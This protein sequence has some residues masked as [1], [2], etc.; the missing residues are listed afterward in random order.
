MPKLDK[1]KKGKKYGMRYA[2]MWL[3][4]IYLY[5]QKKKIHIYSTNQKNI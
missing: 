2:I 4:G 5:T 3:N 1:I